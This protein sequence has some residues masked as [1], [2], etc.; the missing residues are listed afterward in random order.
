MENK[1]K[2]QPTPSQ[3][4]SSDEE[5]SKALLHEDGDILPN[6]PTPYRY[7]FEFECPDPKCTAAGIVSCEVESEGRDDRKFDFPPPGECPECTWK[8]PTDGLTVIRKTLEQSLDKKWILIGTLD[9][10]GE[11]IAA[12]RLD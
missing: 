12:P 6:P 9:R 1:V 11:W 2:K 8:G 4:P 10:D 7:G 5:I 3:E